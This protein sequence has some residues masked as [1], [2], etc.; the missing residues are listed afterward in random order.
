MLQ[1]SFYGCENPQLTFELLAEAPAIFNWALAGLD[2]LLTRG[3]FVN[4]KSGADAIHQMEDL[5]SPISAF[6]RDRCILGHDKTVAAEDLWDAW[7]AW[8]TAENHK[9]NTRQLFG[10]DLKAAVPT[11]RRVRPRQ[12]ADDPD[13]RPL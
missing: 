7:K 11:I 4:P 12:Q 9:L 5:S 13:D 1:R 3:Y 6:L 10:R 2:R 8:C